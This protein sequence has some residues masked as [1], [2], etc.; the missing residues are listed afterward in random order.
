M[1]I[2]PSIGGGVEQAEALEQ[3]S[4]DPQWLKIVAKSKL[5]KHGQFVKHLKAE[6]GMTHGFAQSILEEVN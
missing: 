4:C 2:F 1:R 6:Y 5:D 3:I